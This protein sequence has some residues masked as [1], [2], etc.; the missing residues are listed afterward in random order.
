MC[1]H[2]RRSLN[3]QRD[4]LAPKALED[5]E[6]AMR[7]LRSAATAPGTE[8]SAL[9]KPMENLDKAADKWLKPYPHAAWREN[10]EVLLVALAV[11]MA[12]RTFF[13]QPFKIPTGSMQ[14]TLFGVTSVPDFSPGKVDSDFRADPRLVEAQKDAQRRLRD[15]LVIPTGWQRV[16]DWFQGISYLHVVAVEDG[17]L[18]AVPPP[19][20]ILIFNIKQTIQV[21]NRTYTI[22]FPPDLG[23]V[24]LDQ[25]AGLQPATVF[26]P[27]TVFHRG[28]DIVK[29][30]TQAGDHLFVN[31][32]TY[33]F[34]TPSRGD[35]VV[36]ETKGIPEEQ[37]D[38][39]G[40]PGD[41]FYI[42]RLVGLGG[43]RLSLQ[44]DY[45][46]IQTDRERVVPVGHLVVNGRPLSAST[47]H[48]ENLYSFNNAS[49]R[50]N[51]LVYEDNHYY[52][53]AMILRLAPD[54]EVDV[55]TNRLFV[56][57]DNTMSSLDSRFWGDFPA[58][59]VIGK[60]F[61]VY[62]PFSSRFGWG[63]R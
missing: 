25:R 27:G 7:D 63:Q 33:N 48:F 38:Q 55:G 10:V 23:S 2:V 39:W 41:Q 14:P 24:T 40:I 21:G 44:K 32:L 6:G 28:D 9:E 49:G 3:H 42:K 47:P 37:R 36:F 1:K 62:W 16:K 30:R 29:M 59:A 57:G 19:F 31:R 5:L 61:F 56:M 60:S 50:T 26:Q 45:E 13:L 52:G 12:I 34:F 4:L 8:A 46:V 51:L 35:I 17:E 11:A 15:K 22:W 18:T 54:H 43:D 53:H 20:R 58:E